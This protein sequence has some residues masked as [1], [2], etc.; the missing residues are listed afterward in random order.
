[1]NERIWCVSYRRI[2]LKQINEWTNQDIVSATV[3]S[4][5][6]IW[7]HA[8]KCHWFICLLTSFLSQREIPIELKFYRLNSSKVNLNI[9]S[10]S[11]MWSK[12][13]RQQQE[14]FL[15]ILKIWFVFISDLKK[16]NPSNLK[17]IIWSKMKHV[18]RV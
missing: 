15:L 1:M 6:G 8:I 12:K 5:V 13:K 17:S 10:D 3:K 7:T 4:A 11:D 14:I 9:I 16:S 2:L 18:Q